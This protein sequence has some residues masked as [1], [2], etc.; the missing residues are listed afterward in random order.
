M[1]PFQ[2]AA[3]SM[4]ICSSSAICHN[5]ILQL[6]STNFTTFWI[7]SSKGGSGH[8]SLVIVERRKP[9][10]LPLYMT[11]LN[12]KEASLLLGYPSTGSAVIMA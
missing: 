5:L 8:R 10:F 3:S 11:T 12:P 6:V 1:M 2:S 7:F 9:L 4:L